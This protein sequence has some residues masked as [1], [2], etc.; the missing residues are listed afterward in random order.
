MVD[1]VHTIPG[2]ELVEPAH[3]ARTRISAERRCE[4]DDQTQCIGDLVGECACEDAA[5]APADDADLCLRALRESFRLGAQRRQ[6]AFG[7]PEIPALF[8]GVRLVAQPLQCLL[9]RC[10]RQLVLDSLER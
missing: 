7:E 5:Q 3:V 4:R 8:P 2:H 10:D 1:F 9:Q 6:R